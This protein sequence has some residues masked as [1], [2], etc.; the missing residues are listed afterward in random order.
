MTTFCLSVLLFCLLLFSYFTERREAQTTMAALEDFL[1]GI[2]SDPA[3]E[4]R[5]LV[6][7]DWLEE[8]DDRRR[9]ELLRLHRQLLATRC[10]PNQHPERPQWHQRIVDLIEA[11]VPPCVPQ[12]S[13]ALPGG[14]TLTGSFIP[15]GSFLMGSDHPEAVKLDWCENERPVH[16][17][18][19]TTGFYLGISPVT[20]AQWK[21]VMGTD[22]SQFKGGQRPVENVSWDDSQVFCQKLTATLGGR[23]SV[24][25]PT[26][27]EWEYACRAGTT[28][29][30]HFGDVLNTDLANYDGNYSWNDSPQGTYREET[31][32]VGSFPANAWGVFDAHGNVWEWC[33][34][35]CQEYTSGD[36]GNTQVNSSESYLILRG[37]SWYNGPERCRSASRCRLVPAH[38]YDYFGFRVCF[39]LD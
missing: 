12:R 32:D 39:R 7:A 8:N 13:L 6:L 17:V 10:E 2:V 33:E 16:K 24:H 3:E 1:S 36:E 21:A 23:G 27:A 26:E 29:E 31:T 34:D 25:L 15:P 14:I 37:G 9:A 18:T 20:Q 35:I 22:P 11:G 5:W 4:T 28:T 30:Y 19:L 38:R